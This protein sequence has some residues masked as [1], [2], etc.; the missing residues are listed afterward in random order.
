MQASDL[1]LCRLEEL[2][3]GEA[4]GFDPLGSGQDSVLVVRQGGRLHA[5]RDLCPH[6][7]DTPMAWRRHAYLNAERSHI[8]CAAHGALF[9]IDGGACVRGPCL[10]Q[11]LTP[12][13][14]AVNAAGEVW[15]AGD[16]Q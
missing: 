12:V 16:P 3:D 1:L 13:T 14:I 5:Y 2:P 6:Y 8:V 9:E 15:L 10:G 7:G 4:R 11:A